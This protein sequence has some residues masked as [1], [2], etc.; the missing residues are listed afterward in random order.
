MRIAFIGQKGIPATYGGVEDFTEKVAVRLAKKGHDVTVYCR[1]YYTSLKE[2]RG[3]RLRLVRSIATKHLDALS[4]TFLCSLDSLRRGFDIVVYQ[5]LGPSSLCFIPKIWGGAKVVTII[6]A[7][8][9]QRK[10]W[11][12]LASAL[13]RMAELPAA[14]F[15]DKVITI[16]DALR[17]YLQGKFKRKVE[18]VTPG[19]EAPVFREPRGIRDFGLEGEKYILYLGRLVPEK[20]CHYLI[21]AFEGMETDL[22]LF[23]GGN[24]F[25]SDEY[26]ERLHSRSSSQIVFGG[27][28]SEELKQELLTNAYLY[29][30]PSELEGLPQSV[31]EA[32]SYGRCV[33]V[34]DIPANLESCGECGYTFRNKD[35]EDL[36]KKLTELI[37]NRE[38]VKGDE[39]VGKEY[40]RRNFSWDRAADDLE[41][42]FNECLGRISHGAIS[43][44]ESDRHRGKG[45]RLDEHREE[46][47]LHH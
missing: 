5:A 28:V 8:D 29:V 13:L 31:V 12:R 18:R 42:L 6:H 36:R 32:L 11:G 2:Y 21:S 3:V 22:K 9:W 1:P 40:V 10:K 20:G 33:L 46:L 24:G 35:V 17:S 41:R 44:T 26:V 34:S 37:V 16:S 38:L 15:P 23:V 4:H 47:Q 39:E 25:F 7:L 19:V 30:L 27:Y 45:C 43:G 14:R